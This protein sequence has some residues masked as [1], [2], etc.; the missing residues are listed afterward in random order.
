MRSAAS[1]SISLQNGLPSR[2]VSPAAESTCTWTR[3]S[4]A[5][6]CARRRTSVSVSNSISPASVALRLPDADD[7]AGL[8]AASISGRLRFEIVFLLMHDD[9]VPNDRAVAAQLQRLVCALEM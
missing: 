2:V 4:T 3:A 7:A 8:T 1:A 9:R 5:P 6:A